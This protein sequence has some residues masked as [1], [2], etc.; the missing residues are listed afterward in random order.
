MPPVA[1]D[2]PER[3]AEILHG[4][5]QMPFDASFAEIERAGHLV[6]RH[7][8]DVAEREHL[9]VLPGRSWSHPF[10]L[11]SRHVDERSTVPVDPGRRSPQI[12]AV[13]QPTLVFV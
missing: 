10:A 8:L 9:A 6:G 3:A 7:A 1:L 13:N 11:P 12:E 2:L 4:A 5:E